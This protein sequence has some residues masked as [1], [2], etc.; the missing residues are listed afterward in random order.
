MAH[1]MNNLKAMV[2][3]NSRLRKENQRLQEENRIVTEKLAA[4]QEIGDRPNFPKAKK[5]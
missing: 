4:L 5:R 3:Q 1:S 2:E